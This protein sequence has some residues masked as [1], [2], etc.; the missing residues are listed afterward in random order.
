MKGLR[1][2]SSGTSYSQ[3]ELLNGKPFIVMFLTVQV[4]D[5]LNGF[6]HDLSTEFSKLFRFYSK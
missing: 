4:T 2:T 6:K 5:I 1:V 3:I